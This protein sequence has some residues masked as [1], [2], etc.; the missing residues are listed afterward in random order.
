MKKDKV[1]QWVNLIAIIAAFLVNTITNIVPVDG[2]SIKD[3]ADNYFPNVLVIPANYAFSIWG[4]IYISLI[5]LGIYQALP[6]QQDNPRCRQLGY[7]LTVSS[8]AQIVWVIVFQYRL[9]VPSVIAMLAILI[10]LIILYRRLDIFVRPVSS[11]EKWL[12]N[13]PISIYLGWISVATIVNIAIALTDLK[14][15]GWNLDATT[16]T[17][18]MLVVGTVLAGLAA[19]QRKDIAFTGVFIWA[20]IAIAFRHWEVFILAGTAIGLALVL[21]ILAF[22]G[23]QKFRHD[24]TTYRESQMNL[25]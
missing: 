22:V 10:P 2:I 12:I 5:A 13:F 1:R 9:F 11:K 7:W 21:L 18:I 20:F 4:L 17:I 19:I 15:N 8:I 24:R 25:R 14:W 23:R 3:I 6:D 16:W